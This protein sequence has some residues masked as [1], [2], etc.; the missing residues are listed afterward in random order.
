MSG[1]PKRDKAIRILQ[2]R[3]GAPPPAPAEAKPEAPKA[4]LMEYD[5]DLAT[6][7]EPAP[8]LELKPTPP[9]GED[10]QPAETVPAE[11]QKPTGARTTMGTE[12]G[13][14]IP[15]F[16]SFGAEAATQAASALAGR[17]TDIE[18]RMMAARR[19]R[20]TNPLLG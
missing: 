13:E 18:Q 6:E 2:I 3:D 14:K 4:P 10:W 5:V 20:R 16:T 1:T 11:E 12:A 9:K 15:A 19:A 8:K 7:I 17:Y